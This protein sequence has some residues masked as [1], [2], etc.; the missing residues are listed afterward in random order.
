MAGGYVFRFDIGAERIGVWIDFTDGD[1]GLI[2]TLTGPRV[3][4]TNGRILS[5]LL[6]RPFG[7]RRVLTLIH[8]QALKLWIKRA[9]FRARPEAPQIEV[10]RDGAHGAA[11]R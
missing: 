9:G 4:L 11:G 8:W 6:R 1:N 5:S 7:A 3:P 2:A 10:S